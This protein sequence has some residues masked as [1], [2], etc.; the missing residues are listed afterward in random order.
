M[1][2]KLLYFTILGGGTLVSIR[3]LILQR[4]AIRTVQFYMYSVLVTKGQSCKLLLEPIGVVY[5]K[6]VP[7]IHV[8]ILA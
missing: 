4:Q 6:L 7:H 1:S 2:P 3:L 8:I 5:I